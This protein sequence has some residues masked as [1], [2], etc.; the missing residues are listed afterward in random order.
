MGI[1]LFPEWIAFFRN[2]FAAVFFERISVPG[3]WH[4][5]QRTIQELHEFPAGAFHA[6]CMGFEF[7]AFQKM[8]TNVVRIIIPVSI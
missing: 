1:L 5:H 3:F 4:S 8:V 2:R 6:V 7:Q